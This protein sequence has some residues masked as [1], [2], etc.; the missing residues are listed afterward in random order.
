[1]PAYLRKFT[2]D[3][4]LVGKWLAP[5][6][7]PGDLMSVGGAGAQVYY[8]GISAI[9]AFGLSDEYVAHKVPAHGNRPGH[10]KW[11]PDSYI[12]SRKP[13][14]MCHLYKI[15]PT[16]YVPSPGEAAQ[17]RSLGFRWVSAQ[18]P[19]LDPPYYNFLLRRDRALGPF[20]VDAAP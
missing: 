15:T 5:Y 12:L 10:Q 19:G 9:D 16:P 13:T 11:A 20:A 2:A 17:W 6:L 3:R 1:M 8:A 7:Q 14:L 4:A 18:I